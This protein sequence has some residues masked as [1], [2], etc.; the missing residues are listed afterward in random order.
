[1][2][3]NS[4]YINIFKRWQADWN[5][6]A[7][8]VLHANLDSEQKAILSAVQNEK[9]V[10][11]ASGTSRGKDY[12]AAVAAL[13]F[14]YLTPKWDDKGDLIE[15]TKVAMT[16][17][18]D[19]QVKNIMF[20]EISRL[21]NRA[22]ILPGRPV[23]YDIRT[24]YEEWFLT[25]FKA[26]KDNHEA[27]SGFHAVNTM[28]IVTEASGLDE[29]IYNAIEGNLQNNSRMLIVFNPNNSTGYAARSF[30]Q[31]RWKTFRLDSLNAANVTNKKIVHYG[32]VDYDWV[33]DKVQL[34][35][36][37]I[38]DSDF[39]T[40]KGDFNW[41][42]SLYRPNDLFRIK[43][44]GMF[45]EESED[46]LIPL[47]WIEEAVKRWKV[48]NENQFGIHGKKSIGADIAGMG[49]DSTV[50]CHR[51]GDYVSK[52]EAYQSGGRAEHMQVAGKLIAPLKDGY[53]VYIDTIG[54][55]AGVYSR[56]I[57]QGFSN[58]FSV[59]FSE[60]TDN[61]KDLTG[62]YEFANMRAYLFWAIRD[63]LDPL[64]KSNAML[65]DCKELIEELT[66][67]RWKFQS[68]GKI[69]IEPKDEI[70]KR[71]KRSPDWSDSLANTFYPRTQGDI[72]MS[73]LESV[74]F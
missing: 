63:W 60:G 52:F 18:T 13:C 68:N 22:K 38:N 72:G 12:V 62:V 10:S 24:D 25:G 45:P 42:G 9:M 39:N 36:T 61:L 11:V 66:E 56:L 67:I 6:F 27:W 26:S 35:C 47:Y 43:V 54:E 55:G 20:P 29:S 71:L 59:K 16:A 21:F 1:M 28:F 44:R 57:E 48:Q 5:R 41:E 49:S 70:K 65:P 14:L 58:V 51:I 32:Q 2:E 69:I 46:V 50:F 19:R 23:G 4:D 33:N 30:K 7:K 64:K 3:I 74:F 31:A 15:N 34:W 17:P 8:D 53:N 73:D 40:A 37:P